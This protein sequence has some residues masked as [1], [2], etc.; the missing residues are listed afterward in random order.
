MAA[1]GLEELA[2]EACGRPVG[3]PDLAAGAADAQHLGR[4]AVLIGREHHAERRNDGIETRV[5]E[6]QRLRVGLAEGD[7]EP[8]RLRALAGPLQQRRHVVGRRHRAPAA[9]GGERNVAVAGGDIE[10]R[11]PRPQVEGLAQRLA[12]DLQRGADD[13]VVAGRPGGLLTQLDGP[14]LAGAAAGA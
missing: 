4:G 1:D 6:R 5:R 9:R 3:E 7:V 14:R 11:L 8:V 10:H 13:R 12:D 2:D